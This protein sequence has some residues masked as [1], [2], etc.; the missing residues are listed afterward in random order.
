[1]WLSAQI[2]VVVS[3]PGQLDEAE[4]SEERVLGLTE[5]GRPTVNVEASFYWRGGRLHKRRKWV[6]PQASL[7]A[8]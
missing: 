5:K 8:S 2:S 7:S 1:M 4:I 6:E 3:L